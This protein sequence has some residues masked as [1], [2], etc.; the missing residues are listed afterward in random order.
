MG[1]GPLGWVSTARLLFQD[2]FKGIHF[3]EGTLQPPSP[4]HIGFSLVPYLWAPPPSYSPHSSQ[5]VL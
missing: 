5:M 1:Q 3:Q 2:S 4:R